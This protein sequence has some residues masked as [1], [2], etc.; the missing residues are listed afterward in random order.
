M[1]AFDVFAYGAIDRL[2]VAHV[3]D[4]DHDF[5]QMLHV[6]TSFFDQLADVLHHL[7]GLFHR[8]VAANILSIIKVLRTLSAQIQRAPA[9][10]GDGLA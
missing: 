10:S 7:V 1:H 8:I 4:I 2:A 9:A 5:D 3:G 6:A